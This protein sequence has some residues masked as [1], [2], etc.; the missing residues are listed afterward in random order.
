MTQ[1]WV[2]RAASV[3]TVALALLTL[4]CQWPGSPALAVALA[5]AVLFWHAPVVAGLLLTAAIVNSQRA[6]PGAPAPRWS[7]LPRAWWLESVAVWRICMIPRS[8]WNT[9]GPRPSVACWKVRRRCSW[10]MRMPS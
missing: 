2:L 4:A 6:G 3:G 5:L 10:K 1:V 7:A 8:V 9:C